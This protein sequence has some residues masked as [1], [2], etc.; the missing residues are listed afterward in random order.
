MTS[1]AT[2]TQVSPGRMLSRRIYG[3]DIFNPDNLKES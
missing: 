1:T 2:G 3:S